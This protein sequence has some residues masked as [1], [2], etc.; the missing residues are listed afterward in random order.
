[1]GRRE[2]NHTLIVHSKE[3]RKW[4]KPI[5]TYDE[6]IDI[7]NSLKSLGTFNFPALLNGLF[8]ASSSNKTTNYTGYEN[9][10]VRDNFYIAY[11]HYI[12]GSLDIAVKNINSLMNYFKKHKKRFEGIIEKSVD[13][14]NPMNRPHIRFNGRNLEEIDEKWPHSQN[15]ALGYFVWFYSKLSE[16]NLL[17]LSGD[18]LEMIAIFVAYFEAIL[19]WKDEDSG[20]WEEVRKINASSI[21]VV[22]AALEK[23]KELIQSRPDII[24]AVK[25]KEKLISIELLNDLILKGKKS[26]AK[27]LPFECIQH[28]SGKYRAYDA[29]L[30]FLIY[31][32][33]IIDDNKSEAIL[34]GVVNNLL[35]DYGVRRYL[36]DSYWAPDYKQ[37]LKPEDRSVDFSE[38]LASRDLLLN[39]IGSEAQWCLFDP[40]ISIIFGMKFRENR[41][42]ET[43]HQQVYYLNR[44]LGQ[45]T[46]EASSFGA[47]RCPE[48]YYLEDGKYFP[49]DNTPLLWVQA[50]LLM[51]LHHIKQNLIL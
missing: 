13:S 26:L 36:G 16:E 39:Q 47:Y 14:N 43:L 50:N 10:W 45:I 30:L 11:A 33:K 46:G 4:I 31:P 12:V 42:Q 18:D 1:M 28:N 25:Y 9:I 41:K 38:N 21:G 5:Y 2:A 49:N 8:P 7:E 23:V 27:I 6:I 15:D 32:M 24:K 48:L 40:I 34:N 35:G 37:R 3:L 17:Q 22:V 44:A 29:A 51:A 19:Y 20:H